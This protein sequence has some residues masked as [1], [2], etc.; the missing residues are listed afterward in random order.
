MAAALLNAA[1]LKPE[2]NLNWSVTK[3]DEMTAAISYDQSNNLNNGLTNQNQGKYVANN[4]ISQLVNVRNS[5]S[6]S[7]NHAVDMSLEYKKHLKKKGRS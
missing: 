7:H 6:N 1:A 2:L 4:P 5:N 3:H